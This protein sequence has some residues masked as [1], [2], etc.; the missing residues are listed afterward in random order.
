MPGVTRRVI[1][2]I[3]ESMGIPV[4]ERSV[5]PREFADFEGAFLCATLMELKPITQIEELAYRTEQNALF[6]D[7]LQAFRRLTHE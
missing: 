2:E 3:A 4:S 1:M 5:H 6:R 7:I